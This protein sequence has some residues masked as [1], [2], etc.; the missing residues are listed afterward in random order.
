M[1]LEHVSGG[2]Q[3]RCRQHGYPQTDTLSEGVQ[4]TFKPV[5]HQVNEVNMA[6]SSGMQQLQVAL[7]VWC[8]VMAL[9]NHVE[10]TTS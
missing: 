4:P 1:L 2:Q 9:M 8:S 7:G 5:I 10:A 6:I 3:H